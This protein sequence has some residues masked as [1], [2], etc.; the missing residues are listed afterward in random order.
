MIPPIQMSSRAQS[1]LTMVDPK[2]LD[3]SR[4]GE[5]DAC[6]FVS[7]QF[8]RLKA[9]I[10]SH[11]GNLQPIKI[12]TGVHPLPDLGKNSLPEEFGAQI[13]FG[14]ARHRA[15]LELDLP[16]LAMVESLSEVEALKHFVIEIQSAAQWRPWRL[17]KALRFAMDSGFFP[18]LRRAAEALALPAG[19]ALLLHELGNLSVSVRQAYGNLELT[20]RHARNLIRAHSLLPHRLDSNATKLDF[21]RAKNAAAVLSALWQ[22]ER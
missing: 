14:Y 4:W 16:V 21:G 7:G 1:V 12:R 20:Q 8:E 9:S 10:C 19:D 5:P 11:G 3:P 17:A 2:W 22:E 6:E 15:C 13:V 18:S